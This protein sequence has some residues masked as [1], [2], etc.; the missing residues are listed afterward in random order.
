MRL[1]FHLEILTKLIKVRLIYGVKNW[2]GSTDFLVY[3]RIKSCEIWIIKLP[4]YIDF[5]VL[6]W[7]QLHLITI[8]YN[9]KIMHALN[10][11]N[12]ASIT[13]YINSLWTRHTFF[14]TIVCVKKHFYVFFFSS[15]NHLGGYMWFDVFYMA[16]QVHTFIFIT[17]HC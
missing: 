16:K 5:Q 12:G 10:R 11:N 6:D 2:N 7:I 4:R 13:I 1:I 14:T 8:S 15:A 9:Q 3:K 17:N